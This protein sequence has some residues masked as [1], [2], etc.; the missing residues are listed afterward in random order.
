MKIIPV[1]D[2]KDAIVV[3][4]VAGNRESY[5]AV[6][7]C[8]TRGADP[9]DV[10]AAFV[11]SFGFTDVYVADL[12]AIGGQAIDWR[13]IDWISEAGMHIWLDA[14]ISS[15]E[16]AA[17]ICSPSRAFSGNVVVGL[18]SVSGLEMLSDLGRIIGMDRAVFSLDMKSGQPLTDVDELRSRPPLEIA[19]LAIDAG[20][21]RL[22]ALDLGMVGT[23]KGAALAPLCRK[24]RQAWPYVELTSGGGVRDVADLQ[25]FRHAGCHALLIASALHNGSIAPATLA[26]RIPV[27]EAD[28][29]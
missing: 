14:G 29:S 16:R 10:A 17:E 15:L 1:I 9:G 26:P 8:L 13:S 24:I 7:S 6:E 19:A 18:E 27:D 22:I 23:G 28:R 11:R 12:D 5:C 21:R 25:R 4:G 3:R 20:F 2:L